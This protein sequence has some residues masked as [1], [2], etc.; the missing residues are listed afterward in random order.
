[1][2]TIPQLWADAVAAGRQAPAYLVEEEPGRWREVAWHE[3]ATRVAE[4]ANGLLDLGIAKGETFGVM[5]STRL[6]WA[7]F[8]FALAHVGG[9]TSPVYANSSA[10]DCAHALSLT[11]AVG[12]LV[13]DDEQLAKI[14]DVRGE[15][16]ALRHVLTFA[17]LDG[18]AERGR[19]YAREQPGALA[20][21]TEAIGEDD[22]YT[23]IFTSGTTGMPKACRILH[24]H[25]YDMASCVNRLEVR[26]VQPGD[27]ML[28]FLPLAHNFGR[29]MHL[30][31]PHA[32]FTIAFCPDP[33]RVAEALPQVRPTIF[34][35]VPRL[36]EKIHAGILAGFEEQ[37]G[38]RRRLVGWALRV[39][40]EASLLREAGRPLPPRLA[41]QH[42]LADR[43]VYSKVKSRLGGRL[44][45]CISGGA[46]LA[47][48]I[49]RFLHSLDVLVLEGYG[50]TE[51]TSAATVNRPSRF[52]VGTVGLA[53]PDVELR[54]ADDGELLLRSS[55]NFAG[56]HK[57]DAATR[58]VLD[59]DNWLRT[60]DIATIDGDG[61]V[62]ITDRKK[63]L[64]VTA[65]GKK[66][67]PQN[68]ENDLKQSRLV[69]QVLAVG[70]RRPYISALITLDPDELER[71]RGSGG[72]AEQ[73]VR[74]LVDRVNESRSPFEQIR[75][76]AI[77]PRDFSQAEGEITPTLKLRRRV[78]EEH[79]A[80]EIERLYSSA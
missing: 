52:R 63:D 24:R 17:D 76:F 38:L 34:P 59:A 41:L 58:A 46:P 78:C 9:V 48:E 33:F 75:R 47:P 40:R 29:L 26:I 42:R 43:L 37:T 3:A 39:G 68:L 55:T 57:D 7:L 15:L 51:C 50:L 67:A 13:E 36:F 72:D 19:A 10:R 20:A 28:L 35:S 22:L 18:L 80:A 61:F 11:D 77:L 27:V 31:G 16:P 69:S 44:R 49:V 6:E 56:Y 30:M 74:E 45:A 21:A 8:D 5:G 12:V 23:F 79:F 71:V 1:M 65:G 64:L 66:I 4:L 60:G 70:D 62:T 14:D 2:R 25:Y 73:L 32:G 54:L 53:L